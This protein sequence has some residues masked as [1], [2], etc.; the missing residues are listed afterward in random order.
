MSSRSQ[1]T[2]SGYNLM[3]C[4]PRVP[5]DPRTRTFFMGIPNYRRRGEGNRRGQLLRSIAADYSWFGYDTQHPDDSPDLFRAAAGGGAGA[6]ER[7]FSPRNPHGDPRVA[8][9]GDLSF[10]RR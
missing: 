1:P 2:A 7:R 4:P 6:G 9:A 3:S 8:G 5:F 10:G